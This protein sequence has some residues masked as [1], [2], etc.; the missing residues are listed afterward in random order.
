MEDIKEPEQVK[1]AK[2]RPQKSAKLCEHMAYSAREAFKRL[3][4]NML[5]SLGELSDKSNNIVGITSA[6]P[7]EG[8]STV[9]VNLAYSLGE[10][11]K[12]V[13]VLDCDLRRPTI[14]SNVGVRQTPGITEVLDGTVKLGNAVMRYKSSTNST[15]FD[16][17]TSGELPDNPSEI[18]G[19]KNFLQLLKVVSEV[20]DVVILDLPPVNAVIDAA[21][22][23]QLTDGLILIIREDHCPRF[24]LQD[25]MEQLKYAKAN[26][27]GFV[28]NGSASGAGKRYKY[29]YGKAYGYGYGYYQYGP[30]GHYGK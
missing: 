23:S 27:L 5:I 11:G 13:I 7:S 10:L 28:M 8:K 2:N 22:V 16:L 26:I 1:P 30:Y 9:A 19:S 14:H 15:Y 6:Q 29:K 17:V 24:V 21:I 3:R 20:Y 12:K 18:L 4:T 25:C